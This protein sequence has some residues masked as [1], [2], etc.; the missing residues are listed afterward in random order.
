VLLACAPERM[1]VWDRRVRTALEALGRRPQSGSEFFR[2]YMQVVCSLVEEMQ[3]HLKDEQV[4]PR[5]VDLA[6]YRVAGSQD[7]MSHAQGLG[8]LLA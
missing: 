7:L 5:H 1:A 6:L 8:P 3:P 4:T 2:R